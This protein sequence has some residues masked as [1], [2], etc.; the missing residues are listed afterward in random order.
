L[1]RS[2]FTLIELLVV[3]A[4]IA[5]L[6]AILFPVF[7]RAKEAAKKARCLAQMRQLAASVMMY[8]SDYDDFLPPST[9]RS[10]NPVETPVIWTQILDPFV[11][12]RDIFV[13]VG[14][15]AGYAADWFSRRVQ[16]IGFTDAAGVDPNSLAQP[17]AAGPGT[18]GF[19]GGVSFSSAEDSARTGLFTVT[20]NG[21]QGDTTS[22]HRGYVFN[23]YNGLDSPDGDYAKGLPMISDRSLVE[24]FGDA[25]Y[26]NSPNLSA[27]MLKPVFCRYMADRRNNGSTPVIFADGHAKSY[28]ANALNSFG[29][30]VWRFR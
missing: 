28:S 21:P 7:A 30:V 27:P 17:G 19:R 26:P 15:T 1:K 2:A 29:T 16:S 9:L 8:A 11:K 14:S 25:N 12:N 5:I 20:P 23:P 18:E 4:I 3:I 13:A 22:K 10:P 6:A 24:E